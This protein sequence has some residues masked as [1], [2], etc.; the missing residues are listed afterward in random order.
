MDL[1]GSEK[2]NT[3]VDMVKAHQSELININKVNCTRPSVCVIL[4]HCSLLLF[5][6][7]VGIGEL[8][9]RAHRPKQEARAVPRLEADSNS[10][11]TDPV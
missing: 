2:W 9:I 7:P 6:E 8:R 10:A 3:K 1:A 5:T 11:G 4:P